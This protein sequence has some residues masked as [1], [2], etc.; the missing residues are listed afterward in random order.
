LE[1]AHQLLEST[2]EELFREFL[3]DRNEEKD[4]KLRIIAF[5]RDVGIKK[6]DPHTRGE[7]PQQHRRDIPE[8]KGKEV[9][10]LFFEMLVKLLINFEQQLFDFR[11]RLT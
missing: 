6:T 5:I 10:F 8:G 4:H 3:Y 1:E 7:Q 9:N 2:R 11:V